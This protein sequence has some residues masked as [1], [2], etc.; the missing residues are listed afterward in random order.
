MKLEPDSSALVVVDMQNGFCHPDGSLY[1]EASGENIKDVKQLVE[2]ARG[3][4]VDVVYTRD[5][6]PPGQFDGN[7][8]YDEFE[9]WGE[10]VVEDSWE[11]EIVDELPVKSEDHVVTKHTYDAFHQTDLEGHLESHGI[12]DLVICG[13]LSNVCVLHTASSAGLR[14][15]RPIVVEDAVGYIT[16]EHKEYSLEHTDWLF[17]ET[18]ESSEIEFTHTD[19]THQ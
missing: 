11:A 15:Y 13:T 5:V 8:Y 18:T 1:A 14:D 17:G 12:K 10:H 2:K 7:H 3:D 19:R 4:D 9:R 16:P 6:H